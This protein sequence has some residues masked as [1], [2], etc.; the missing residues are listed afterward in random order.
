MSNCYRVVTARL[1][2]VCVALAAAISAPVG[3]AQDNASALESIAESLPG[4]TLFNHN[5]Q[6]ILLDL[7][8]R[9]LQDR[10]HVDQVAARIRQRTSVDLGEVAMYLSRRVW[11]GTYRPYTPWWD[12]LLTALST[13]RDSEPGTAYTFPF[14]DVL[15]NVGEDTQAL[16]TRVNL[17]SVRLA[18]MQEDG[19]YR[20][21]RP[22][23]DDWSSAMRLIERGD[24]ADNVNYRLV[25]RD[26]NLEGV[27][28]DTRLVSWD[29]ESAVLPE[30]VFL[31]TTLLRVLVE[32]TR[33]AECEAE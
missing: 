19:T 24:A 17:G 7:A 27:D 10:D 6:P 9:C 4:I 18:S 1:L 16:A 3:Y 30:G 12:A 25:A 15:N 31:Q 13:F 33:D 22:N 11:D 28:S 20:L 2:L 21:I 26:N 8:V 5:Q 23:E 29:A 32:A 14:G